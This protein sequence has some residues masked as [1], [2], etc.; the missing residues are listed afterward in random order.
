[1]ALNLA[2]KG[3]GQASPNPC[4]GAIVVKNDQSS[5]CKDIM[6]RQEIITQR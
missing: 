3:L 4:V 2:K 5:R 1:M 6:H